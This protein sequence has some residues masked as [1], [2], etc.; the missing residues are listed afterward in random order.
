[1]NLRSKFAAIKQY[2]DSIGSVYGTEDFSIYLYSIVKMMKPNTIVELGTGLGSTALWTGLAM[3][4]NGFGKLY[5]VDDGSEWSRLSTYVKSL[6]GN[7]YR[8]DY[9]TYINNLTTSFNLENIHLLN[10]KISVINVNEPIDILFTDFA[11]SVFDIVTLLAGYLPKMSEYSKIYID[12]AST[13]YASYSALE[14][15]VSL[16][17][18]GKIP[19][20]I[21]EA[22]VDNID[23]TSSK[24]HLEHIIENKNRSQNS[25]ACITIMPADI[26]CYPRVGIRGV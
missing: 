16:L 20:S 14:S 12:S 22:M 17:N 10:E 25:T 19:A 26:F 24:Y 18:Q 4:E 7:Y 1:M 6:V 21:K 15:I 9:N 3:Q 13:N 11:H 5:T 2:T 8:D 23:I